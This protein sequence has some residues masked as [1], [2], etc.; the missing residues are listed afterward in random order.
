MPE[1]EERSLSKTLRYADGRVIVFSAED[2]LNRICATDCCFACGASRHEKKFNDEHVVPRWILNRYSLFDKEIIL[3]NGQS[4]R[5]GTYTMPCCASCNSLL[6]ELIENPMSEM[7]SGGFDLVSAKIEDPDR[8]GS[9]RR[10]ALYVWLCLIFIK[11][12]LKDRNLRGHLDFRDGDARI[13]DRYDW[14]PMHHIHCVARMPYV[15]G[16]ILPDVIGTMRWFRIDDPTMADSFDYYDLTEDHTVVLRLGDI[17]IVAVL[18]DAGACTSAWHDQLAELQGK[19]MTMVQLRELAARLAVANRD[20]INRPKFGTAVIRKVD[21]PEVI[22]TSQHDDYPHF[23]PFNPEVYG[24]ILLHALTDRLD[25]IKMCDS[26]SDNDS[27][28]SL[29][30]KISSGNASFLFDENGRFMRRIISRDQDVDHLGDDGD[31]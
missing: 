17:G 7:L 9:I 21:P 22:L 16:A 23:A 2:F 19:T 15:Q 31:A 8:L 6:G 29:I 12:H 18:T 20:L 14:L 11:T 25:S 5:Y 26:D 30:A 10:Q 13:A 4:H 3:P 27:D 1:P 24:E 28:A